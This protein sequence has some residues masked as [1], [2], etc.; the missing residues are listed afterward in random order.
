MHAYCSKGSNS[1]QIPQ[2]GQET[3]P[4]V[5]WAGETFVGH[6]WSHCLLCSAMHTLLHARASLHACVRA[7][8]HTKAG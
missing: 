6:T 3:G 4:N 7:T 2:V 5:S 1:G 8:W